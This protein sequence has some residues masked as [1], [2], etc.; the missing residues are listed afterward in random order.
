[1]DNI[2]QTILT[3]I[4]GTGARGLRIQQAKI[5]EAMRRVYPAGVV[6]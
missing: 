5:R 1:M 4:L 2:V 6:L 3:V